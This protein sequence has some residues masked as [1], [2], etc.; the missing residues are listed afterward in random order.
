MLK[1]LYALRKK[2]DTLD[3]TLI[4]HLKKRSSLIAKAAEL[5]KDV[6]PKIR[7]ARET[8]MAYQLSK[9]DFGSYDNNTM[10][11]VWRELI[12]ASLRIEG[13]LNIEVLVTPDNELPLLIH[14]RDHFGIYSNIQSASCLKTV[15]AN[16][17][18]NKTQLAI[19]PFPDP[20]VKWWDYLV[21]DPSLKVGLTLPFL[22]PVPNI[23]PLNAVVIS[24]ANLEKSSEDQSLFLVISEEF[25]P[26]ANIKVVMQDQN[27]YVILIN[28]F[29]KDL[30]L[31]SRFVGVSTQSIHYLG[32]YP[33]PLQN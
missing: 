21:E 13:D 1:E 33:K 28:G 31:V 23:P 29:C 2:I 9:E 6:Y 15:M 27:K 18:H 7:L 30:D 22:P 17:Q 24:K 20:K 8:N 16:L 14:S 10:Q 19:V 26:M 12:A 5:K 3:K 4:K 11:K 25:T 32:S